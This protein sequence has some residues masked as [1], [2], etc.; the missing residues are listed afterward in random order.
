MDE[1][2]PYERQKRDKTLAFLKL[3]VGVLKLIKAILDLIL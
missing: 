1:Q 2:H 3:L